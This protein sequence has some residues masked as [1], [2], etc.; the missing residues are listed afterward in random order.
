MLTSWPSAMPRNI[1]DRIEAVG[2]G[3]PYLKALSD[4]V[5]KS[6]RLGKGVDVWMEKRREA[7]LLDNA[8][9]LAEAYREMQRRDEEYETF[10][11]TEVEPSYI[12]ARCYLSS[13]YDTASEWKHSGGIRDLNKYLEKFGPEPDDC[14]K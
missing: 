2:K 5:A 12:L 3:Y 11:L 9:V 4:A 8:N 7:N 13:P 14:Y 10:W 1:L 6:H